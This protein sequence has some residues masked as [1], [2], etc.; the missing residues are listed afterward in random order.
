MLDD[1]LC[2]WSHHNRVT[3]V[4]FLAL[5]TILSSE[6]KHKES[7][8]AIVLTTSAVD[9]SGQFCHTFNWSNI[10]VLF[11]CSKMILLTRKMT[12][13]PVN[14]MRMWR[15]FLIST[16]GA[17]WQFVIWRPAQCRLSSRLSWHG[18]LNLIIPTLNVFVL[19]T[20]VLWTSSTCAGLFPT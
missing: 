20:T 6:L 7:N 5:S 4:G 2:G 9:V 13:V 3:V 15:Q 16:G 11:K 18:S 10:F 12:S 19:I 1:S 14:W 8:E 17:K